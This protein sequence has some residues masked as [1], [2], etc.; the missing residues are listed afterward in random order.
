MKDKKSFT[1]IG[2]VVAL[3]FLV[4]IITTS[5]DA[6]AQQPNRVALVVDFGGSHI[7]RCIEFSE[8]EITGY[9]VLRRAGLNVVADASN[10]MGVTICDINNTSGCSASNCFCQCQGSPCIYWSYHYLENG[11][12]QYSQL[13][14][15]SRKVHD[16]DVEGW[17][18]GEGAINTSGHEPP[19]IP[20]DQICAPPATDTPVPTNTPIPPTDTPIPPTDTPIPPTN[21]P[22]PP[23]DTPNPTDTPTP[24]EGATS[25][26]APEAWFRLDQNPVAVSACTM[27]RWDTSNAEEVYLNE[28]EVEL[29]GSREVCPTTPEEYEL[30]VVGAEEEE[31]YQLTLSVTGAAP[32]ATPEVTS[33]PTTAPAATPTSTSQVNPA[34]PTATSPAQ[35]EAPPSPTPNAQ[36]SAT[37]T[38]PPA[39]SAGATPSS[40][41]MEVVQVNPTSTPAPVAQAEAEAQQQPSVTEEDALSTDDHG[42]SPLQ[43]LGYVAFSLIVGGLLGW[44]VYIFKFQK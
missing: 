12:W 6:K 35:T 20:F 14:A 23:T 17:G 16:G 39:T 15:S 22:L 38:R 3:I 26:P 31:Q 2:L 8:S 24:D 30:R 4:T 10:P 11:S 42:A 27:L 33:Q 28:E 25:A 41:P 40:T 1:Y 43:P 32:T 37:A 34:S 9:D 7:T 5:P 44:L 36:P 21:T 19:V 13:G 18:W 29:N